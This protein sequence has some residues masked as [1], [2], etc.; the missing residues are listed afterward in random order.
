M[1]S[2]DRALTDFL[3]N[4]V[5]EEL[6]EQLVEFL[7]VTSVLDEF[8]ASLCG[9]LTG[10][11]DAGAIVQQLA[12]AGMFVIPLDDGGEWFRYHHLFGAFMRARLRAHDAGRFHELNRRASGLLEDRHLVVAA[13]QLA[14][15]G[16]DPGQAAAIVRR[17]FLR[18]MH[19]ADVE[20]TGAACRMWLH[21]QGERSI[22]DD[23]VL[24]LEM[25]GSLYM[26]TTTEEADRWLTL[27]EAAHPDPPPIVTAYLHTLW[28]E[29]H[30]A[31]GRVEQALEHGDIAMA[32]YGGRP[33]AEGVLPL[34]YSVYSRIHLDA[35]NVDVARKTLDG[36]LE[37]GTRSTALD[38]V[39][40]PGLRAWVAFLDGEL[41]RAYRLATEALGHA[42]QL[43][44][45]DYDPGRVFAGVA[46]AGVL[47]ERAE[48]AEAERALAAAERCADLTARPLLRCMVGLQ[49]AATARLV[50]DAE[51]AEA[52][53]ATARML[54]PPP[55]PL[56]AVRFDLEAARQAVQFQPW[57]A[58]PLVEAVGD[59]PDA[60]VLR[61]RLAIEQ[62]DPTAATAALQ[63]VPA[64][65][66]PRQQLE[67]SVLSALAARDVDL[68]NTHLKRALA[69]AQPERFVRTIIA[70]GPRLA[71]LLS[72]LPTGPYDDYVVTLL[73]AS[74][75]IVAP[76]RRGAPEQLVEPL[77]ERE[78]DVLRYLS[79]RLTNQ[80]I[81]GALYVSGNTLKTHIKN[82]Y[83]KLAVSS[84][85]EA[86]A[87]GRSKRLI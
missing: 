87:A 42:D 23:P 76:A 51:A 25:V 39:R 26:A 41:N 1:A 18:V 21:H 46:L 49:R 27:V 19:T 22:A 58:A 38:R 56:G 64:P 74:A 29:F 83:R 4:E 32:V 65:V 85:S 40:L 71:K 9:E 61:A 12:A 33:P 66:T 45:S 8:D 69:V 35:G 80:E 30:L 2:T 72:G 48:G 36:A 54:A 82:V 67:H 59:G 28:S 15:E 17:T 6:P 60:L 81:A 13:M 16:D 62:D 86:V 11:D 7:S 55:S 77:T 78:V 31:H 37:H 47:T 57:A 14:L 3:V 20:L 70:T 43:N 44:V 53:L 24:V 52:H 68:A 75:A 34:L 63:A 5:L 79:S 84:R 73:T 10:R 50:G